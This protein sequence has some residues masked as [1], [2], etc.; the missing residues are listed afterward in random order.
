MMSKNA[1]DVLTEHADRFEAL[2]SL[3]Q[4]EAILQSRQLGLLVDEKGYSFLQQEDDGSWVPFTDGPFRPRKLSGGVKSSLYLEEVDI[5]LDK[6]EA[7]EEGV[8]RSTPQV[9]ILS[10]GEMTPFYYELVF[11][12]GSRVR[13]IVDAI[14][15]SKQEK[16][17]E[18]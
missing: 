17:E 7:D 6:G 4:D 5:V 15:N 18:K 8:K 2:M 16:R 3:A 11:A 9:F 12:T 14:G 13:V 10:S 1:D